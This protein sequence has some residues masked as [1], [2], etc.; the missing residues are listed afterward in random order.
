MLTGQHLKRDQFRLL[1]CA[2]AITQSVNVDTDHPVER[3]EPF[4][5]PE[6]VFEPKC[7]GF[8]AAADTVPGQL[9]SRNGHR[10]RRFEAVL[11]ALPRGHVFDG[12]LVVL[13]DARRPLN[14]LLFGRGRTTYVLST[15]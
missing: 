12:E 6:W 15:C 3:A 11:E 8:R 2:A 9:I 4:D 13:D 5:H 14:A 10:M 1:D 7:D